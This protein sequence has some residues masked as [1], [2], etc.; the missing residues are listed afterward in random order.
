MNALRSGISG[1]AGYL[2]DIILMGRSPADLQ[3]RV[4][5]VLEHV[6]EYGFRLWAE[7]CQVFLE[8]VTYLG[9]VFDVNGRHSDPENIWAM[10]RMPA[11]KNV[12]QRRSFRGLLS[13][14][15]AFLLSLNDVR[16]PINRLLQKDASWCWSPDCEKAF[17]HLKAMLS[18][19]LLLRHYDPTRPIVVAADAFNHGVGAVI[20][21]TFPDGSEK[22][23]VHASRKLAPAEKNYGQIGKDALT[24]GIPAYIARRLQRCATILL[25]YDFDNRYCRTTYLGQADALFRL[26]SNQQ[27]PEE[28]A[29]IAAISIED[30]VRNQL[31]DTIRGLPV[32]ATDIRRGTEQ[33]L[34]L[35]QAITYVQTHWPTTAVDG[36]LRQLFLR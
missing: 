1:T 8:S 7:K 19:D 17:A 22:A 16:A 13:Y 30:D 35:R 34:V 10:Q 26:I 20:S 4:C 28:D 29:V 36:N 2:D 5:A 31:S 6:Q 12:P 14:Y 11:P 21:H 23:I 18:S 15:S 27:E 3:D 32:T 24:L 33:Y 25:G 9:F